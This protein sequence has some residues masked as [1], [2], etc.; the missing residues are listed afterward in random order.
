MSEPF[1]RH[2]VELSGSYC[3]PVIYFLLKFYYNSHIGQ[4]AFT[5]MLFKRKNELGNPKTTTKC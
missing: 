1:E 5:E 2:I 4:D 3:I